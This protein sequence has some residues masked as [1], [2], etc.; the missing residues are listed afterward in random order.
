MVLASF[1]LLMLAAL[2][3]HASNR[4]E[5]FARLQGLP[6]YLAALGFTLFIF[7]WVDLLLYVLL[8]W[9]TPYLCL[10]I[11]VPFGAAGFLNWRAARDGQLRNFAREAW[12]NL[13]AF[14]SWNFP[15]LFLATLVLS[16]FFNAMEEIDGNIWCNFNF[17][18]MP[19][20]LS[21]ARAFDVAHHFPPI[22]LDMAPYPLKYHFLADFFVAH[23]HQLGMPFLQG[24]FVMNVISAAAMVGALWAFAEC[25]LTLRP[26]WILLAGAV[27][28]FLNAG[29]INFLHY[30]TLHPGYYRSQAPLDGI[31]LFPFFN[32]ES[33][34]SNLLE[35]QRGF[36]FTLP[37]ALA[38][39]HALFGMRSW[40]DRANVTAEERQYGLIW[41]ACLICLLP[42]SHVVAFMVLTCAALPALWR[43]KKWI[44][45]R[46]KI[47][48]AP[49]AIGL[50]QVYYLKF[51]GPP[52]NP[53]FVTRL[54]HPLMP[55]G[56]LSSSASWLRRGAF[57]FFADGDFLFW[58]LLF[59]GIAAIKRGAL[60]RFVVQWRWYFVICL[61][62]F[63][64]INFFSF[65]YCWGDSNK[66]VLFLNLGLT[67]AI[68]YGASQWEGT[69]AAW[70]S[71]ILWAFFFLL[72]VGPAGYEFYRDIYTLPEG[73]ILLFQRN[74][75]E[76][77]RWLRQ[78]TKPNDVVLTGAFDIYHFVTPLG[79]RPVMAG[80]YGYTDMYCQPDRA[81]KIRSIYEDAA[82]DLVR[83]M[84]VRYVCISNNERRDYHLNKR[85][86]TLM[87]RGKAIAFHAGDPD[88]EESVFIF[89]SAALPLQ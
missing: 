28:L 5:L 70:R 6:R 73:K 74:D 41:A 79:G 77:A 25:W 48:A 49:L 55:D 69:R 26:R 4:I 83:K 21:M 13:K 35:P 8:G 82:F 3:V 24:M 80:L 27:F 61:L 72:S 50:L 18:D 81:D 36:L 47:W 22:D 88:D 85:W 37:V 17:I 76:A 12:A 30:L 67:F 34:L 1:Y 58:G 42:L 11:G 56:E 71:Q 51:Y 87:N 65:M 78:D 19:F 43:E 33:T 9:G 38:I 86:L 59:V 62:F 60:W 57:W 75:R 31:L 29:L 54:T 53:A 7:A 52:V 44:A 39:M 66:F 63:G 68:V 14:R 45:G 15:F 32:F 16:R 89:D 20:H 2:A 84:G 40:A 23:L 10:S 46:W 64:L